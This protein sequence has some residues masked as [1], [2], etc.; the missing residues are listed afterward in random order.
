MKAFRR[1]AIG[2]VASLIAFVT[3]PQ[4][5]AWAALQVANTFNIRDHVGPNPVGT[6]T[7]DRLVVGA[8]LVRPSGPPT[9]AAAT[10]G[11]TV[12]PLNFFPLT[13][14]PDQYV[15]SIPFDAAPTG[16]WTITATRDGETAS[17]LTNPIPE[18]RL[19]PLVENVEVLGIGLTPTIVWDLPDLTGMSVDR[20]RIRVVDAATGDQLSQFVVPNLC[21]GPGIETCTLPATSF[22]VP[23]G[24]LQYGRS[25]VFRIMLDDLIVPGGIIQNRSNTFSSVYSLA[26]VVA[27]PGFSLFSDRA[28]F[29]AE[30]GT[31]VADDYQNPGY[32]PDGDP[33][34]FNV[35]S[36]AA[37]SAVVGE[38]EY[39]STFYNDTNLVFHFPGST[40]AIYCSGC[41]GSYQLSFTTTSVGDAS[42]VFGVGLDVDRIIHSFVFTEHPYAF[43]TF[44]DGTTASAA[45]AQGFW[46]ITAGKHIRSIHVGRADGSP[47]GL[48]YIEIDNLTLGSTPL[49]GVAID[50]KPGSFPNSINLSSHGMVPVA[51]LG[52]GAFDIRNVVVES[53]RLAGAP[54]ART[55]RGRLVAA[56]EDVNGD[57]IPDLLLHFDTGMLQLSPD[58]TEAILEGKTQGGTSI[59]GVDSIRLVP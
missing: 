22:T 57:G 33:S 45:L 6:A 3:L 47:S 10:Q 49:I 43:I 17:A 37:M 7:G 8:T 28:V 9:T 29:E 39:T 32:D 48:A 16:Q 13:L 53:V 23:A 25:Y 21:N 18:P 24:A 58:A 56:L 59:R 44:G 31:K 54:V 30:L 41:N 5:S 4:T 2:L 51:I 27:G 36:N 34:T 12:Q 15:A 38:T 52:T 26:T 11:T 35:L 50:I 55:A 14:F 1:T 40:D 19:I 42:G 20:V 46:G